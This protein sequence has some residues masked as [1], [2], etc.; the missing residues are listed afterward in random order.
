MINEKPP[1]F[2]AIRQKRYG[3]E[4]MCAHGATQLGLLGQI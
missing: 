2:G 3:F 4:A 1:Q